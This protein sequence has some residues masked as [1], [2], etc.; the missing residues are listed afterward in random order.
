[1]VSDVRPPPPP[2]PP[3]LLLLLPPQAETPNARA[4]TRQLNAATER[5]RK[6]PSSRKAIP[7]G[8]ESSEPRRRCTMELALTRQSPVAIAGQIGREH[9]RCSAH[10]HDEN[11]D[12]ER[13]EGLHAKRP[14]DQ[15]NDQAEG[16]CDD[17]SHAAGT[18]SQR[19]GELLH[20]SV[21]RGR[22]ILGLGLSSNQ[23]AA[24]DD[25]VG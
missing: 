19:L 25:A 4:V 1:M 18:L 2:P 15:P 7:I 5:T 10:Q 21:E 16:G 23:A 20:Q 24:D 6:F 14:H 11:R 3:P 22:P 13:V 9:P 8:R 12:Q 17:E